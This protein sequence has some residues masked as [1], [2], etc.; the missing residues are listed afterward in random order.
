MALK[1]KNMQYERW[2]EK[3]KQLKS[4]YFLFGPRGTG[5]THWIQNLHPKALY[6][7]LLNSQTY[8]RLLNNPSSLRELI[9]AGFDDW[10]ILDEVQRVPELLN[11]VHSLIES[12]S[13]KFCMTGSS[14][15]KLRAKGTN[16][17]AGRA[18]VR[19]MHP[20][21]A[22]ELGKDFS[23]TH[24]LKYGL[25]PETI[26]HHDP[27]D[28]LSSYVSTY[29]K[30]EVTQEGVIRHLDAFS[31]ALETAS[32]SQGSILNVSAVARDAQVSRKAMEGYFTIMEDLLLADKL[33]VFSKRAKR[34]LI[35]HSKFYFFDAGVFRTLRPMGPFDRPEEADG[36]ALETLFYQHLRALNDYLHLGYT[37]YFWHTQTQLEVDFVLYG[38][39][40]LRA[41]EIKRSRNIAPADLNGLKAFGNDYPEAKL[42]ILYGG[43][44]RLYFGNIEAIPFEEA[45]RELPSLLE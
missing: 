33:P 19:K 38:K 16:L 28:Y 30:E 32:Y 2:L 26:S 5:K 31:R 22:Q 37:L 18:V 23:L 45:L 13:Y 24:A 21:I 10:I 17:L 39:L 29:L 27:E 4:S 3:R 14:A 11:E 42:Y 40:G 41:F 6:I 1:G 8:R 44:C 25:L 12:K 43:S 35:S 20:L 15:R 7:D 36:A 34:K 9:P